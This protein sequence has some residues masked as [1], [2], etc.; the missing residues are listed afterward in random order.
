MIKRYKEFIKESAEFSN[1]LGIRDV[2]DMFEF[3]SV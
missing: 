2:Y 3:I 1:N